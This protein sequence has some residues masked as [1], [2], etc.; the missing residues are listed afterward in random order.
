[1]RMLGLQKQYLQSCYNFMIPSTSLITVH[2]GTA[3]AK[4]HMCAKMLPVVCAICE[5]CPTTTIL[6]PVRHPVMYCSLD[7]GDCNCM[8]QFW[9]QDEDLTA[10]ESASQ[11]CVSA[12]RLL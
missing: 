10:P 3:L 8:L 7:A 6:S 4:G 11:R 2:L 1:M 9:S 12:I 5:H